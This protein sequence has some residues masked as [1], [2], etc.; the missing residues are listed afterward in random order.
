MACDCENITRKCVLVNPCNTGTGLG[1]I[2]N[3]T[4][5]WEAVLAFNGVSRVFSF[6][7]DDGDEISVPTSVLN[8]NYVHVLKLTNPNDVLTC[9]EIST[10]IGFGVSGLPV[11]PPINNTWQWGTII[12]N[13]PSLTVE[14]NLFQGEVSPIIWANGTPIEWA[15]QG[16][17]HDPETLTMDF[18]AIGGMQG[19]L[20]FQY[21]ILST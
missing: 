16:V 12:V 1:I 6:E 15:L 20:V 18:T 3:A 13:D 2:A 11:T 7:A 5:T 14:D 21:K 17:I 9:Y 4:G 10:S 19:S 8:E